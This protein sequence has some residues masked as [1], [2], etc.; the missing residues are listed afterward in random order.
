MKI[1]VLMGGV[2]SERDVSL[3]SGL[4]ISK[5]LRERGHD[6]TSLDTAS[7]EL[8][9]ASEQSVLA[10][11]VKTAPP[12]LDALQAMARTSLSR[13]RLRTVVRT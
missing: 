12:T 11:G 9:P 13:L 3:A 1:T 8:D 4:R 5:A 2:S 7:G 10:G 6:V